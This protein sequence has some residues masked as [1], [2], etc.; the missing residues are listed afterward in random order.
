LISALGFTPAEVTQNYYNRFRNKLGST[1]L[2]QE[3][4]EIPEK[5]VYQDDNGQEQEIPAHTP[6]TPEQV[7]IIVE[8]T[9]EKLLK[10]LRY[11]KVIIMTDADADGEHID[12]LAFAFFVR[13]FR[14]L[15]ENNRLFFAVTPLYR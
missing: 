8:K 11:G 14:Y 12:C 1:D 4:L 5:F 6:L 3:E 13:Y 9:Q 2:S 7:K 10:K 15:I